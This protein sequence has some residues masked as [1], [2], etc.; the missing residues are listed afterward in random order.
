MEIYKLT[1]KKEIQLSLRKVIFFMKQMSERE[2]GDFE[3]FTGWILIKQISNIHIL[4]K[5]RTT[6]S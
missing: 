2:K 6:R 4:K 5:A 3:V 1:I